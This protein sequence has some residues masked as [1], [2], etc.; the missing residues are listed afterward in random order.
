M[1]VR[2]A[3][4]LIMICFF[5]DEIFENLI[6]FENG[7]LK[8]SVAPIVVE[9]NSGET[10]PPTEESKAERVRK[11]ISEIQECLLIEASCDG[12]RKIK[13]RRKM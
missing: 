8:I 1:Q 9:I 2:I 7:M 5:V 6:S 3:T 13:G 12:L 10:S 11:S 4:V